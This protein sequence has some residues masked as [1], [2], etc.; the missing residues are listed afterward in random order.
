MVEMAT[1]AMR[2][3]PLAALGWTTGL[4]PPLPLVAVKAPVFSTVK[5]TLVD[6]ALGP[7]MKSTGEVMGID[8]ELGPA[9]EKAFM[10]ALGTVP[11]RGGVLC[12][13]ADSDKAEALPIIAQLSALGFEIFATAG[14]A[15]ALANAGIS[16]TAVGRI[17]QSRPNVLDIIEEGRVTLVLNSVSN[18]ETDELGKS[19]DGAT[20]AAAGRTVK[21]GY[22]IR[23]AAARRRI[24]CCTSIDTAA[25]L[26][27]A[28]ARQRR[29][30]DV[31]VATVRAYREA[32]VAE[33]SR[34]GEAIAR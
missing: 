26:V 14:T 15:A 3:E 25:A 34:A 18:V 29:G 16:A 20:I 1:H 6:S 4:V 7:E 2:G 27:D 32:T 23:L 13:I 5:L 28:M 30:G 31:T 24:A 33:S 12:S 8:T 22:R 21:D 11:S 10:A 19:A 9:L 17:G